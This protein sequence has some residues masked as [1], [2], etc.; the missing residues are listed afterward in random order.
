MNVLIGCEK[1]GVIRRAFRALGHSAWSCDVLPAEDGGEHIQDDVLHVVHRGWDL[2]IC[3]PECTFL[4]VANAGHIANGCNRYTAGQAREYQKQA[5]DFFM[6]VINAPID[7]VCVE[8]PVGVMSS[9]YRAPDQIVQP[10]EYGDDASKKTCLWLRGLPL[11]K[12]TRYVEPRIVCCNQ[13]VTSGMMCQACNGRKN[14]RPRWANQTDS[15]QNRLGPSETR[16]AE[17][18]RTYP[19]IAAAMAEQWGNLQEPT[20]GQ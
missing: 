10:Y 5:V 4:T 17:R 16:S 11:L 3:H 12:P 2:F 9:L 6:S 20:N 14:G 7:K 15:G 18:A 8:N 13:V 19:G 1:S